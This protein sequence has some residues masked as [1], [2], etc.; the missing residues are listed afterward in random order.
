MC[1]SCEEDVDWIE[2]ILRGLLQCISIA[3]L[4]TQMMKD[5]PKVQRSLVLWEMK[6]VLTLNCLT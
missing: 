3:K 6:M 1:S 4:I 5:T 2:R